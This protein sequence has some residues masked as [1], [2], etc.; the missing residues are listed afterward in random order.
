MNLTTYDKILFVAAA[1]FNISAA[2]T[3]ILSP[4]TILGRLKITDP[5]AKILARSMASSVLAWGIAYACIVIDPV[6]FRE[7]V[8]LGIFSKTIFFA[9]YSVAFFRKEID[10]KAYVPAIIDLIL[11][12]LFAEYWMRLR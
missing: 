7:F 2:A 10:F 6:R 8:L 9:V 11:A 3:L 12:V 5:Q 4:N 1:A